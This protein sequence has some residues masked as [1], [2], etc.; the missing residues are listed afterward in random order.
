MQI[1]LIDGYTSNNT[2]KNITITIQITIIAIV[3]VLIFVIKIRIRKTFR[4]ILD[5]GNRFISAKFF[6]VLSKFSCLKV[7]RIIFYIYG[8]KYNMYDIDLEK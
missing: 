7:L 1:F 5:F 4:F 6:L 3:R 2:H 8:Y